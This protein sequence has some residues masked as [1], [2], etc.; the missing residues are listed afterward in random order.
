MPALSNTAVVDLAAKGGMVNQFALPDLGIDDG[1]LMSV[2]VLER[3]D[4]GHVSLSAD[5]G[6]NLVLSGDNARSGALDFSLEITRADGSVSVVSANVEVASSVQGAGWA[7]GQHYMLETGS[8]DRLV[9]E[10]GNEHRKVFVSGSDNAL[11]AADIAAREGLDVSKIT[12]AWLK[13]HPEY[14]GSAELALETSIGMKLWYDI[15]HSGARIGSNHLLFERGHEY[16]DLGRVIPRGASGESELAPIYIGAYGDGPDPVLNA[17]VNMYQAISSHVVIEG[18]Q[19]TDG[20]QSLG[21][22]NFLVDD[23]ASTGMWNIQNVDGFTMRNV[24]ILDTHREDPH[25]G[26]DYWHPSLNRMQGIFVSGS[27]DVLIENT[28]F[29]HNGW[30]EGYNWDLTGDHQPPSYYSHNVYMSHTN[31]GVTFRDNI[32]MRGASFGAQIR[33]GGFLEDNLFLDNNYGFGVANGNH[34]GSGAIGNFSLML[35]NVVTSGAHK[36]VMQKEGALTVGMGIADNS[37]LIDNIVAFAE[38]PNNPVEMA[39]KTVSHAA[40]YDGMK[41]YFHD[42][43]MVYGW[44]VRNPADTAPSNRNVEGL[45][46]ALLN[47]ATIQKF[48]AQL[49]GRETATI[50]DLATYLRAQAAGRLDGHVD[51]DVINGFFR[52]AFGIGTTL[53]AEETKLTFAPAPRGDGVRWDNRLNWSTGDLPGTQ[54]GDSVDLAGNLVYYGT[55]T[56]VVQDLSLGDGADF[57]LNA[58]KLTVAGDLTTDRDASRIAIDEAG[59]LFFGGYSDGDAL[60]IDVAGGR[61][62]NTGH[63]EGGMDLSVSDNGQAIIAKDNGRFVAKDGDVISLTG[64]RAKIGFDDND[65]DTA[66]LRMED[67]AQLRFVADASGIGQIAEFR[68]GAF[69][70]TGVAADVTSGIVLDGKLVIDVTALGTAASNLT[71]VK[72]DEIIGSFDEIEVLGLAGTRDATLRID[73]DSDTVVLILG[74]AGAGTGKII[75]ET[76]GEQDFLAD[77]ETGRERE[78]WDAMT[79]TPDVIEEDDVAAGAIDLAGGDLSFADSATG[80]SIDAV[81]TSAD[82]ISTRVAADYVASPLDGSWAAQSFVNAGSIT[83]SSFSDAISGGDAAELINGGAGDDVISGG[84]GNDTVHGGLGKD[85]LWGGA[86]NDV[87]QGGDGDDL[88]WGGE[89]DD[90][91]RLDAGNDHAWGGA[92]NDR[93]GGKDGDDMIWG[94]SSNDSLWGDRGNDYL[95]GDAGND[96]IWG[97]LGNDTLHGGSGNDSLVGERGNDVLQGGSGNDTLVGGIGNDTLDGGEGNDILRGGAGDDILTGGEGADCFVLEAHVGGHDVVA[98]FNRTDGDVIQVARGT[99][100]TSTSSAEGLVLT[101]GS[102]T[103]LVAGVRNVEDL[104]FNWV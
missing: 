66:V 35:G 52:A 101:A 17:Q 98:D 89:G 53:R 21:G 78:L 48:T 24:E 36:R 104:A 77:G 42:D 41:D 96:K 7:L 72:A 90:I 3:P 95:S 49:L 85:T 8:D 50:A 99:L 100:V 1:D 32:A 65:G 93:I 54:D 60:A 43:T 64:G 9:I 16:S 31:T 92:G 10:E 67:G 69:S 14:G 33:S 62:V 15:G 86:G 87:L 59:Q 102:S 56:Q 28:L 79:T 58:G 84:A 80:V 103:M 2:R 4:F 97:G 18:L 39:A 5:N 45:D 71:L 19:I 12:T 34:D 40:Y 13:A 11:S 68:S 46:P 55:R 94:G 73:Y 63:V 27:Q 51:A 57:R 76:I 88:I 29:D 6:I 26:A 23:V 47:Q 38:D 22:K 82:A 20:V 83:G 91:L 81:P 61:M 25:V 44:D 75:T 37:T 30:E 74:A 70:A